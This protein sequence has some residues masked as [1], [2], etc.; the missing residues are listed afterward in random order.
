MENEIANSNGQPPSRFT[1]SGVFLTEESKR[2]IFEL[3]PPKFENIYADHLTID[4]KPSIEQI[5]KLKFGETV[6]LKII[7]LSEDENAQALTVETNLSSNKNPHITLST[8]EGI[9]PFYSNELIEKNGSKP[10]I[11][12]IVVQG[13]IGAVDN[14]G[15]I[16]TKTSN[17]R[18]EKI[19]LPTRAQ[20]DTIVAIFILK[21]FGEAVFPGIETARLEFWQ[22]LPQGETEVSLREKGILLMDIGAGLFDHHNHTEK[23]TATA[24][25]CGYLRLRENPALQKLLEYTERDDFFGKGTISTDSLDRAFGLSGLI[26]AL[27]KSFVKDPARVVDIVLPFISAHYEEELRRTD[28]LPKEFEEKLRE[29][30]AEVF[31]ARQ[32][33]KNLRVVIIDSESASMP[34]YLRS[35]NGGRFDVVAQWMPSGHLNILT[36]PT[37]HI[38]LRS[39]AAVL[40][41]EELALADKTPPDDI[42]YLA[43]TGRLPEVPEWYYDQATNSIQNGGLNPKEIQNTKITRFS[44]K[45]LLEVG[46][47]ETL[48]NPMR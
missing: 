41:T 29:G 31:T 46:L 6:S 42:H 4:F 12:P 21:K 40:R 2:K 34:G 17:V 22:A 37:K 47:S 28:E 27:N 35:Q 9:K 8:R 26:S 1:Y 7:G 16:V 10:L 23:T 11:T 14:N 45:K 36:R 39:L 48:W 43:K 5:N 3:V 20:P 18:F 19:V 30:K 24:L 15:S 25:V 33:G 32:R 38:D 13:I 44:L